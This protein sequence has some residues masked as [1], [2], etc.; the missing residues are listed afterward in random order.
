MINEASYVGLALV[1]TSTCQALD[2]GM[3]GMGENQPSRSVLKAIERLT[4]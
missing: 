3:K 2:L 1:C 4:T